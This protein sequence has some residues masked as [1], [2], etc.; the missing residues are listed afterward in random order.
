M[1]KTVLAESMPTRLKDLLP[2][3]NWLERPLHPPF[4]FSRLH[5]PGQQGGAEGWDEA[6]AGG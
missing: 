1:Q 5:P 4:P 3:K 2:L 6:R